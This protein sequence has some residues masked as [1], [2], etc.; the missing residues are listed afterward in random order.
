[1]NVE[2]GQIVSKKIA[3]KCVPDNM[4]RDGWVA[5]H[6]EDP[7]AVTVI[8][9]GGRVSEVLSDA[10]ALSLTIKDLDSSERPEAEKAAILERSSDLFRYE[11]PA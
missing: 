6:Q 11:V 4:L 3:G 7:P 8:V 1:M 2:H 5:V 10:P 9:E